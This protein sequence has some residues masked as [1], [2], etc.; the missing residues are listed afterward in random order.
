MAFRLPAIWVAIALLT[1]GCSG[2]DNEGSAV[3]DGGSAGG[4]TPATESSLPV[5]TSAPESSTSAPGW[6]F[7]VPDPAQGDPLL[8]GLLTDGQTPGIDDTG[9]RQVFRATVAYVNDYLNGLDGRRLEVNECETQNTPTGATQCAVELARAGVAAVLVPASAQDGP[10]FAVLADAGIP[11][12][13]Y[14]SL[15]PEVLASPKATVLTNLVAAVAAPAAIARD[16]GIER[17]AIVLI[18]VPGATDAVNQLGEQVFDNAGVALDLISVSPQV[19]D[20]TPQV[21]QAI[22]GGAGLLSIGGTDEF[23]AAAVRA[24]R[25]LGYDGQIFF[26]G[27]PTDLMIETVPGGLEG[28]RIG[29]SFTN[30][31]DNPDFQLFQAVMERYEPDYEFS[32]VTLNAFGVVLGFH[33][34]LV[35]TGATDAESVAAALA[36][37]ARPV[38]LPLGGGL[39]FQCGAGAVS[40]LPGVCS[41]GILLATINADHQAVGFV[42][43]DLRDLL[44]FG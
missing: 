6:T 44:V 30:E 25:Q 17:V 33:R 28:I 26:G 10:A 37:M 27:L 23:N 24:A 16:E 42:P 14:Q 29:T 36:A 9:A 35:G 5:E 31:P 39:T 19:A 20:L 8:I 22:G 1:V 11:F 40:F 41:A 32:A 43:T 13:A 2:A 21:Q 15:T 34:A 3:D 18:D 12:V 4:Q 7:G 38:D